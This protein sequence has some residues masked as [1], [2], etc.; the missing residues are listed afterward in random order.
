MSK[1]KNRVG[2]RYGT[3]VVVSKAESIRYQHNTTVRWN[4]Q[5]DCGATTVVKS[6]NLSLGYTQSCGDRTAHPAVSRNQAV[7]YNGTHQKIR[8]LLGSA[9]QHE[10]IE[11]S[12]TRAAQQWAYDH[13]DPDEMVTI[14]G[15]T[16]SLDPGHYVPMCAT[17][18]TEFD[19]AAKKNPI[20]HPRF[21]DL[22]KVLLAEMGAR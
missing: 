4:C 17:H 11:P 20:N 5:C 1:I 6:G 12:C 7:R 10:C 15:H 8:R 3:L 21:R 14:G 16:Y 2:Q 9:R 13:Q 19:V 22:R 18:H